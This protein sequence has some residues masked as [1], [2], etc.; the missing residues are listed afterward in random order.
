MTVIATREIQLRGAARR[1]LSCRD[2]EILL[3]GSAGTGK[4]VGGLTKLH[5]AA[6]KY[7][8]FRG[9][10][11]RKTLASLGGSTLEVWRNQVAVASLAI[12]E[13]DFYGGSREEPAQYRYL[14][15]KSKIVVGGLDKPS[16]IMSSAY[17]MIVIDEATET[18]VNDW[19]SMISRLRAGN[20]PYSQLIGLCNPDAEHH[21]LYQ[22]HLSGGLT[23]MESRHED[24][25]AYFNADGTMTPAGVAY[26][27]KLDK[28]TGV[29]YLRL[30][31]GLWVA[32][33][34]LIYESW[35]PKVHLVDK[36]PKGSETWT[37]W[38]SV[39]FGYRNPFVLQCWAEDGDGRL[40]L[41]REI[42]MT[43]RL[44]EDHARQILK[45]VAPYGKWFEPKPRA[46]ICDH[47]AEDRATLERHLG[48]STV[49]AKKDV[50]TGLEVV[51]ARLRVA[52]DGLPRVFILRDALVERDQSLIDS[53]KPTCSKEEVTGYVWAKGLDG[54][55]VKE[56]PQKENDHGMDAARYMV[57]ERDLGGRPGLR[58]LRRGY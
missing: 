52:D 19:E 1:L 55:P 18:F 29:R 24:N 51:Q 11:L 27:A 33:E 7:P 20:M 23:L 31:R 49:A 6:M 16:K 40:W 34:G 5:L 10:L 14:R 15:N 12:G 32:A 22:R 37:R 8:E 30:R 57:A 21:Y 44:V 42:Y 35:D 41:Y 46:I 4:T 3:S 53:G 56:E 50:T 26:L 36:L 47:D 48:M 9:L 25:P 2:D 54:R 58:A 45:L 13:I 38:W 28:L 43:G 17:D 39:D